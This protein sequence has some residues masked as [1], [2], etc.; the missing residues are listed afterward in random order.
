LEESAHIPDARFERRVV[1]GYE[2]AYCLSLK[3]IATP[4]NLICQVLSYEFIA[5]DLS[6][7]Q[8]F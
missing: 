3:N 1:C 4:L 7:M 2:G 8:Q 5:W 6:S